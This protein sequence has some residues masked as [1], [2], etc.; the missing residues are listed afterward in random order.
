MT[1]PKTRI[2]F[3]HRSRWFSRW[4]TIRLYTHKGLYLR[5][6][7]EP[8][9]KLISGTEENVRQ[10]FFS[11]DGKLIGYFSVTDRKLKKIAVN[12]GTQEVLCAVTQFAG[13]SCCTDN[14]I[15]YSQPPDGMIRIS[16]NGGRKSLSNRA[17]FDTQYGSSISGF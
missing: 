8:T 13:A 4:Q 7:D 6:L 16:S 11:P 12:G 10:L 9:A 15:V 5:P 17:R 3:W 14:T 1:C 2:Q